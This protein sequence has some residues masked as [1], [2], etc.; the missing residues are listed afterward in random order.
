MKHTFV[1]LSASPNPALL[2]MRI[3]AHHG[4]D[5]RF[6]FLKGRYARAWRGVKNPA[7]KADAM[8][9]LLGGYESSE[10]E[11][12]EG[13]GGQDAADE[14]KPMAAP[15]T[16]TPDA[17]MAVDAT[18]TPTADEAQEEEKRRLRREKARLWAEK[19]KAGGEGPP[20]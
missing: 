9:S 17:G 11:D 8:G 16:D 5:R 19:R 6:D 4:A 20:S 7:P 18:A 10:D 15:P 12:E 14:A 2:E 3:L 13:E 1:S